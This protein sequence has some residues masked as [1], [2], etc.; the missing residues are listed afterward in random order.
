MLP[1]VKCD[2]S[3]FAESPKIYWSVSNCSLLR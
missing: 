1:R 3:P 2:L